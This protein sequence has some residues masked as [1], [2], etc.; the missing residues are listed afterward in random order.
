MKKIA[1]TIFLI[2]IFCGNTATTEQLPA[3]E[4]PNIYISPPTFAQLES[5]NKIFKIPGTTVEIDLDK[6]CTEQQNEIVVDKSEA[7]EQ[8]LSSNILDPY[9]NYLVNDN[10][11]KFCFKVGIKE[12]KDGKINIRS[13]NLVNSVKF[14]Q[15]SYENKPIIISGLEFKQDDTGLEINTDTFTILHKIT[16]DKSKKGI[17]LNCPNGCLVANSTLTGVPASPP[18]VSTGIK[19]LGKDITIKDVTVSNFDIGIDVYSKKSLVEG[20]EIVGNKM[21]GLFVHKDANLSLKSMKSMIGNGDGKSALNAFMLE[22]GAKY[23]KTYVA[24]WV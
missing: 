17:E 2:L 20:C 6:I 14:N 5:S 4:N 13:V 18:A 23:Q 22:D 3:F 15:S 9:S 21:Y 8:I 1:V 16:I 11:Y 12:V 24:C 10:Y 19:T 7:I